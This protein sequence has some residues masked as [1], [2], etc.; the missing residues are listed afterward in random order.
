[1]VRKVLQSSHHRNKSSPRLVK[2]TSI[3]QQKLT[4]RLSSPSMTGANGQAALSKNKSIDKQ[5][6]L[7]I[8][9]YVDVEDE[10]RLDVMRVYVVL[11]LVVV[12]L[13]GVA[14]GVSL[15]KTFIFK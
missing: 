5:N 13:T 10:A 4:H 14:V 7:D 12:I 2:D 9:S 15:V 1:M 6:S 8:V 3:D 11:A